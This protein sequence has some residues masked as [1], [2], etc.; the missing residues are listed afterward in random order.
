MI[1]FFTI[2]FLICITRAEAQEDS[3]FA[4][5]DSLV[6]I[7]NY[8][9]A[10]QVYK[11][12]ENS[13]QAQQKIAQSYEALGKSKEA[14]YYYKNALG[15]NPDNYAG[16]YKY[17]SLLRNSGKY[18]EADSLFM[19]LDLKHP[20]NASVLYQL[21]YAKE[22]LKDSMATIYYARSYRL[23][24]NQQNALYRLSKLLLE[25]GHFGAAKENIDKGLEANPDSTRF[26]LLNALVFFINKSYHDAVDQY[27]ALLALGKDTEQIR[28]QLAISLAQTFQYNEAIPQYKILLEHFDDKNPKWHY[29]L[30]KCYMGVNDFE[31]ARVHI[32]NSIELLDAPLDAQ[33]VS[34]AI[35][36]NRE[37]NFKEVIDHLQIAIKENPLNETAYYQLAVAADN[38][39]KSK[40]RIIEL[41]QNYLNLFQERGR[42]HELVKMRLADLKKEAHL[43]KD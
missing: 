41:Y 10:I 27:D 17:G 29:N 22:Q 42:Y 14:L 3:A 7:G 36:Y 31:N 43:T 20:N 40:K 11:L 24:N 1:R 13:A 15:L 18:K 5:A 30:G 2:L 6:R 33:F 39:Y 16:Q 4:V 8:S 35:M 34:L 38:Y 28:E 9:K 25:N 23:D 37:G 19:A 26:I 32:N 21:G 12:I